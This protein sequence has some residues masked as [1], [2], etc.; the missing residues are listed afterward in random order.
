MTSRP[1]VLEKLD[2]YFEAAMIAHEFIADLLRELAALG[3]A[4]ERT[5]ELVRESADVVTRQMP[6]LTEGIRDLARTWAGQDLL[7]RA[8][9]DATLA[10][11][12]EEFSEVEPELS[13]LRARQDEI[14]TILRKLAENAR[15]G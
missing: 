11:I 5:V 10:R 1:A 7:D 6:A 13:A 15:P 14:A 12:D 3:Q 8:G 4:D 9:A 2:H